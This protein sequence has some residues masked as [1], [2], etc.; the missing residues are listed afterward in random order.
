[1]T[2]D[3]AAHPTGT[4]AAGASPA[5]QRVVAVV[6]LRDGSSGK[7]RLATVLDPAERSRLI[8]VLARYVVGTLLASES[9]ERVLVV[10]S[11]PRFTWRALGNLAE[12]VPLPRVT[13]PPAEG[14]G[15]N[16][17]GDAP[18]RLQIVLQPAS[19]P[20]LNA[21]LD[22]G[23]EIVASLVADPAGE[24][25]CATA[26]RPVRLLVAHA[27]LPALATDDVEALLAE[28]APVVVA[29]DRTRSGTNLLVLDAD[30]P[31]TFRF[32]VESLE[33]HLAEA[34]RRGV[35][36]AVV[37]RTGTAVD[38]D[39]LDDWSELPADVRAR[40]ELADLHR[41]IDRSHRA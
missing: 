1:M 4:G 32:G 9:V 29:T 22:V 39:T 34:E 24:A 30:A 16:A 5:R 18:G 19:R 6:P 15:D 12:P 25:A 23:R 35:R 14:D 13:D 27:D 3:G 10:T 33:A 26:V 38:L 31:F 7:S 40:D 11:D 20:G 41:A 37:Q 28:D 8:G 2:P 17:E 21:A 36:A